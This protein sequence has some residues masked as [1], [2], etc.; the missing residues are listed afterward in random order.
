M[1]GLN[2]ALTGAAIG[3]AVQQPLLV[4]ALAIVSHFLLDMIPHF[5][6]EVYRYGGKYYKQIVTTDGVVAFLAIIGLMFSLPE[7]ALP[8]GLGA[9][10]AVAPDIPWQ[11]YYTHGRPK[12]WYFNFHSKIQWFER[13]PGLLVEA[14]YL[15]F[16]GTAVLALI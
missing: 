4:V 5:D 13:P 6:H 14:S 12:N 11:Y 3:L 7:L 10:W 1:T 9:F 2:H 8:I 15:I 16:I